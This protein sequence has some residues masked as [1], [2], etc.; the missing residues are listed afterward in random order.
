MPAAA[1]F[2]NTGYFITPIV[3]DTDPEKLIYDVQVF[4]STFFSQ[5]QIVQ[6]T[7][8]M[9]KMKSVIYLSMQFYFSPGPANTQVTISH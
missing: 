4:T 3:A 7:L 6:K 9:K 2:T 5:Q 1:A 8:D